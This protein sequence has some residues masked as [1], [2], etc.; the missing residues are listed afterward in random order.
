[1]HKEEILER[2]LASQ[3]ASQPA[4]RVIYQEITTKLKF[5]HLQN[6]SSSRSII[7]IA[8][9]STYSRTS[10][11]NG[12]EIQPDMNLGLYLCRFVC[13]C[14]SVSLSV[15]RSIKRSMDLSYVSTRQKEAAETKAWSTSNRQSSHCWCWRW[16]SSELEKMQPQTSVSVLLLQLQSSSGFVATSFAFGS[17]VP[18]SAATS[19]FLFFFSFSN[20]RK[21]RQ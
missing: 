12:R 6:S 15:S 9:S 16:C 18:C 11:E 1:M 5:S 17:L 14:A 13:V 4:N 19:F 3:P 10:P 2:A 21:F 20:W 8:S 7:D